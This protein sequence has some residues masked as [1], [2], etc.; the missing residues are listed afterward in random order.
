[1]SKGLEVQRTEYNPEMETSS[2]G[3]G[4]TLG[5]VGKA[6]RVQAGGPGSPQG[7]PWLALG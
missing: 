1:M 6:N 2:V 3:W 4:V 5:E 7:G